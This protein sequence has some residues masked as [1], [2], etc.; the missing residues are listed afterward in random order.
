MDESDE[1]SAREI[2][3]DIAAKRETISETV[4]K[5]TERIHDTFDWHKY[6]AEYPM[7]ALGL[8]AGVGFLVAG[9]FKHEPTPQERI[10]DA[11]ADLADDLTDRMSS[12]AGD[13]VKKK[14]VGTTVKAAVASMVTKAA[15]DFARQKARDALADGRN[16]SGSQSTPTQA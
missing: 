11:V 16:R 15:V 4:D 13:L 1:R 2:R 7:V 5:L 3:E 10:M 8:A 6:V 12:A 9:I 14:A